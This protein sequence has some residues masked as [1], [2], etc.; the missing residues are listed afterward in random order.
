[1]S[2]WGQAQR[3]AGYKEKKKDKSIVHE[4]TYLYIAANLNLLC[5]L[6]QGTLQCPVMQVYCNCLVVRMRRGSVAR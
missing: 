3:K 1:M 2:S 5:D 4:C 6:L